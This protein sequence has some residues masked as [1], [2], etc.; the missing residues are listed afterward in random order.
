MWHAACLYAAA[1]AVVLVAADTTNN[2]GFLGR[3]YN[4]RYGDKAGH[5]ALFGALSLLANLSVFE[6]RPH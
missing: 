5:F 3:V 2:L 4:F 1:I 6:E